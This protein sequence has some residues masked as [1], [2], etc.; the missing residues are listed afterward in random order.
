MDPFSVGQLVALVADLRGERLADEAS[1]SRATLGLDPPQAVLTLDGESGTTS[2]EIGRRGFAGRAYVAIGG[3]EGVFVVDQAIFDRAVEMDPREWRDR[4]IFRDV[5]IDSDRVEIEIGGTEIALVRDRKRWTMEKP[6]RT[7]LSEPARDELL[8]ALGR[9]RSSGF[10]LDLPEDLAP[11]G[12]AEPAGVVTVF[13]TRIESDAE[14]TVNRVERQRLRIGARIGVGSQ[15][16]FGM[17]DGRPAIVRVSEPVLKALFRSPVSLIAATGSGVVPADVKTIRIDGPSGEITIERDVDRWLATS[18]DGREIPRKLVDGLL[19]TLTGVQ[20]PEVV[21]EKFPRGDQV[22]S[23]SLFG[24]TGAPLD[25]VRV[26]QRAGA[27]GTPRWIV[28]NGDDVLR[29][30]SSL[31]DL[32]LTPEG[33]GLATR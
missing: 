24:F 10:V 7:R 22:A 6:A 19:A 20:A 21:L 5:G 30:F 4:T 9:A 15:D 8:Q 13:T 11:F 17:L 28:E 33:F 29:V 32:R 31:P 16:R 3:A 14:G 18:H 27:D 12:L 23:I 1:P 25:T 2:V 26:A